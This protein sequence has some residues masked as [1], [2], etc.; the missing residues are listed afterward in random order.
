MDKALAETSGQRGFS[1]VRRS[2]G[3]D[4]SRVM[5]DQNRAR[6]ME[7]SRLMNLE[8]GER[9]ETARE[10]EEDGETE[11]RVRSEA[12]KIYQ[13]A[14]S[15][16]G[17]PIDDLR[18]KPKVPYGHLAK[19]GVIEYNGVCFVCDEKT[20][21]ICL[22]DMTDEKNVLTIAL[23]GGGHLKVNRDSL[24]T[25]SKAVGMFSPED[26]NLIMRAIARDTKIQSVKKEIEDEKAGMGSHVNGDGD[27][28]EDSAAEQSETTAEILPQED[29]TADSTPSGSSERYTRQPHHR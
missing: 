22:G 17:N 8:A 10:G 4:Y 25:L 20:N 16:K 29:A 23:S 21:S 2:E 3:R 13:A 6:A 11:P 7:K 28:G 9:E 19:D 5:G 15:G 24:G 1:A 12:E 14:V 27:A 26:L 18:Q